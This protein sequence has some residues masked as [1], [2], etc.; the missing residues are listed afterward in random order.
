[1]EVRFHILRFSAI[2]N[3]DEIGDEKAMILAIVFFIFIAFIQ[4]QTT[5][6]D[7]IQIL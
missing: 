5:S 3:M 1:M 6:D 7:A 2:Y 4:K